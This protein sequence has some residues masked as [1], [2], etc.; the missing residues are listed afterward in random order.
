MELLVLGHDEV[1]SLLPMDACI[2]LMRGTLTSLARGEGHQ[3]L[4]SVV[5]VPGLPGFLGLMPGYAAGEPAA[6]GMKFLGI[7]PGNPKQGKDAHQGLVILLDPGTGEPRAILDA[8]AI[9]AVRTAAVSAVATDALARPDARVLAVFGPG[10]QGRAHARALAF[11]RPLTEIRV[12]GR[13]DDARSALDGADI[14][15]TAT[16]SATP[17]LRREW[18]SPGTHINAVGSSVPHTRELDA[19]TVAASRFFVDRRES[20]VNESGDYLMATREAGLDEGHIVAEI[21][22]VLTGAAA[23]RSSPTELTVFKSLGL[24]VEDLAAAAYVCAAA[25]AAGLGTRVRF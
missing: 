7:F 12:V 23:G 13:T 6:L 16:N 25:E 10:L 5:M 21:G 17:V 18:L 8:S 19:E 3:P 14:V 1:T 22:E 9:T 2:D 24:A 11:V 20:T 15:V 4:R